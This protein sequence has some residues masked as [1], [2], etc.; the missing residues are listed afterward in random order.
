MIAGAKKKT[1]AQTRRE[2]QSLQIMVVKA[3]AY[4]LPR[5][6]FLFHVPNGG[7]RT[8]A[9][10]AILKAM[11]LVAGVHDLIVLWDRRAFLIELKADDGA[12]SAAQIETHPR[13]ARTGCP[14]AVARSLQEV[15]AC[16]RGWGV[17]LN[18]KEA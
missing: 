4:I 5:D 2:E 1:K 16:L 12:L 13:I 9:E 14:G 11:G 8:K 7:Y 17:P 15:L 3:L 10:A 6:A 18:I